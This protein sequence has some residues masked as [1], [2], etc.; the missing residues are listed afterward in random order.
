MSVITNNGG[1]PACGGGGGTSG[2]SSGTLG[3]SPG[4]G[5]C[6]PCGNGAGLTYSSRETTLDFGFGPGWSDAD[7]LPTLTGGSDN[8]VFRYGSEKSIMFDKQPNGS[9]LAEDGANRR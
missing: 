1:C 2:S 5:A 6:N 4:G 7:E 9:Y 8:L 3:G